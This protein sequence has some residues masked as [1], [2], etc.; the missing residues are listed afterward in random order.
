M[1]TEVT[2][3]PGQSR[4]EIT[5]DGELAGFVE[6][7]RGEGSVVFIHTEVDPAFEGKGIG[8]ALARGALDD[9]RAKGQSVVPLCPFIKKWIGKHPDYQDLVAS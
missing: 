7:E 3:N 4:Y 5:V 2:D 1:S 9:V 6:Y 8:G